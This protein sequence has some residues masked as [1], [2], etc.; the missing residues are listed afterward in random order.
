M[1]I[2]ILRTTALL[3][4]AFITQ[5]FLCHAENNKLATITAWA[6]YCFAFPE[7]AQGEQHGPSCVS[8]EQITTLHDAFSQTIQQSPLQEASMWLDQQQASSTKEI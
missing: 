8:V 7:F 4:C 1:A 6:E 5:A 3:L 2:K